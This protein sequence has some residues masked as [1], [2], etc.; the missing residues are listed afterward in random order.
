MPPLPI[1]TPSERL[2][3]RVPP[4]TFAPAPSPFVRIPLTVVSPAYVA[5][6]YLLRFGIARLPFHHTLTRLDLV[7]VLRPLLP[8]QLVLSYVPSL[9]WH[10]SSLPP[11]FLTQYLHITVCTIPCFF[12][13][14]CTNWLCTPHRLD[15]EVSTRSRSPSTLQPTPR[16][17]QQ[18]G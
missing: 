10:P 6:S 2:L 18:S 12:I 13:V 7:R 5:L 3:S 14:A 16:T 1:R 15:D 8:L 9:F 17:S 4:G 11:Q